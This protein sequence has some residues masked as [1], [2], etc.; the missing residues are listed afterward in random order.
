MDLKNLKEKNADFIAV[1]FV[2]NKTT[3][4]VLSKEKLLNTE[5]LDLGVL[6]WG[7]LCRLC[8]S[9][10]TSSLLMISHFKT[11]MIIP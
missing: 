5:E 7:L 9:L 4:K 6:T 3:T 8:P 2:E 11:G 1:Q 10:L